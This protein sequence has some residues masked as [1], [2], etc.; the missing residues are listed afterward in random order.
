MEI[1]DSVVAV[2]ADHNAAETAVKKLAASG[3]DMKNLSLVGRGY[4]TDEK[5][6]GFY[7]AGDRIKFWGSRGAFW[8]G[9]WGLFFGGLFLASPVTGPVVVLGF[10]ATMIVAGIENAVVVGGVRR[11][12]PR[13]IASARPKTAC[14]N[15]SRR[16]KPTAFSSWRAALRKRSRAPNQSLP[17]PTRRGWIS[18][19]TPTPPP[20]RRLPFPPPHRD[21]AARTP[22]A[23]QSRDRSASLRIDCSVPRA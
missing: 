19:A 20:R 16:S 23:A 14:C 1:V 18:I 10:L 6:V 22:T 13:S 3:F 9:F 7:T 12:P 17:P 8:G 11:S 5:V 21:S 15:T 4:H 2:F